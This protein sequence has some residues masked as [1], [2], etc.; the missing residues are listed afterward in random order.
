MIPFMA[1]SSEGAIGVVS[2]S[3]TNLNLAEGV[4]EMKSYTFIISK[5]HFKTLRRKIE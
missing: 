3:S 1:P 4:I 2:D 5:E